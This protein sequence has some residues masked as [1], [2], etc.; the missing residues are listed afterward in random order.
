MKNLNMKSEETEFFNHMEAIKP[1]H[2]RDVLT[3]FSAM[4]QV[5]MEEFERKIKDEEVHN[6]TLAE[7]QFEDIKKLETDTNFVGEK[8][9]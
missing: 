9:I 4:K 3:F 7:Q 8:V 5:D 1:A 2:E 6:E